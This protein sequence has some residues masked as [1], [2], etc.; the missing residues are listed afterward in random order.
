[1]I[2]SRLGIITASVARRSDNHAGLVTVAPKTVELHDSVATKLAAAAQSMGADA[3][4]GVRFDMELSDSAFVQIVAYGTAVKLAD[5]QTI[6][7]ASSRHSQA[8]EAPAGSTSVTPASQ[9]TV[10]SGSLAANVAPSAASVA[11]PAPSDIPSTAT[12]GVSSASVAMPQPGTQPQATV[13]SPSAPVVATD[14]PVMPAAQTPGEVANGGQAEAAT[15][16]GEPPANPAEVDGNSAFQR[17]GF[18]F[19][20]NNQN[21]Q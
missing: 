16:A 7:E 3:V 19:D 21:K 4:V 6:R 8:M 2:T 5:P 20:Q 18:L 17:F 13:S 10:A 11:I 14:Q 15:P 1:V 12:A 9:G